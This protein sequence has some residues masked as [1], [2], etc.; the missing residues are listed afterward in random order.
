[1]TESRHAYASL[2]AGLEYAELPKCA[3]TAIKAALL[4]SDGHDVTD[5]FNAHCHRAFD[6]IPRDWQ[7]ALTFTVVRN[8]FDRLV[9]AYVEKLQK[10]L[11]PRLVGNCPLPASASFDHWVQWVTDQPPEQL[12][13]HWRPQA[14]VLKR[15][16]TP[17]LIL[18]FE[19]L[20]AAWE[21]QPR[22]T[23]LSDLLPRLDRPGRGR[24]LRR[25]H[26]TTRP[27]RD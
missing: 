1:M 9:S 25:G 26:C 20:G 10:G 2:N 8:P 22:K 17:N 14:D 27:R 23:T 13:R 12:D 7:P 4:H 15:R 6:Q 5:G 19:H 21:R 16:R 18:P 11:A 3:C 24:L